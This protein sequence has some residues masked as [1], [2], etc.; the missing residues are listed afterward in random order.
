ML[1]QSTIK[2]LADRPKKQPSALKVGENQLL[3]GTCF[4]DINPVFDNSGYWEIN[5][6][7]EIINE[8]LRQE[9]GVDSLGYFWVQMKFIKTGMQDPRPFPPKNPM[10]KV[11]T[12]DTLVTQDRYQVI[13]D[14]HYY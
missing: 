11:I 14:P 2:D 7:F 5:E 8:T 12:A 3:Y 10:T 1:A 4:I 13:P 6:E 9:K